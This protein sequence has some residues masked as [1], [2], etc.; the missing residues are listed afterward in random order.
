MNRRLR[1]KLHLGEFQVLGLQ[2]KAS[3]LD[4]PPSDEALDAFLAD[5]ESRNISTG[6]GYGETISA[7]FTRCSGQC[8]F[9]GKCHDV[10]MFD[11]DATLVPRL[12]RQH[13]GRIRLDE[14][15]LEDAYHEKPYQKRRRCQSKLPDHIMDNVRK[16]R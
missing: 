4:G 7:F 5:I 12:M 10:T 9:C 8:Q 6:G 3:C 13:F 15:S 1:K 14:W 16:T 2:V 11:S